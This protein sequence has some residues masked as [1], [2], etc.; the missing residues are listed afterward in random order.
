MP[1]VLIIED[2]PILA[3]TLSVNLVAE[4]LRVIRAKDGSEGL[5]MALIEKPDIILLDILLPKID[6]L[7]VLAEIRK[8][9]WGTHVPVIVLSNVRAPIDV[10]IAV[11]NDVHEYLIKADWKIE[12]I[13][14]RVHQNLGSSK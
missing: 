14:E 13:I 6:G 5:A 4:G 2:D 3:E 12:D 1:K 8:T 7:A 9:P 11:G 10:A